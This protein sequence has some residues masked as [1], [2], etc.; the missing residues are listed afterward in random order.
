MSCVL[1]VRGCTAMHSAMHIFTWLLFL[2]NS[3]LFL[4]HPSTGSLSLSSA[5][6]DSLVCALSCCFMCPVV[7]S[8]EEIDSDLASGDDSDNDDLMKMLDN[9]GESEVE[10]EDG[11]GDDKD[12][13][14]DGSGEDATNA[15]NSTGHGRRKRRKMSKSQV[16][17]VLC[18]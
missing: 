16:W 13:E 3:P 4:S 5:S 6:I 15:E 10:G 14:S 17:K 7:D 2:L 12:D 11:S 18:P 8:D 1:S 9:N